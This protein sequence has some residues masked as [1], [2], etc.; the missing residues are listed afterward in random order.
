MSSCCF[1]ASST[2]E[3]GWL[4]L[5][6]GRA[7]TFQS[8]PKSRRAWTRR[9][10]SGPF[11]QISLARGSGSYVPDGAEF[12]LAPFCKRRRVMGRR[13]T[14]LYR[15]LEM[16]FPCRFSQRRTLAPTAI[17][18]SAE[19]LGVLA[20]PPPGMERPPRQAS[21]SCMSAFF[22]E[23]RTGGSD[24]ST[25]EW[26]V[27]SIWHYSARTP[28]LRILFAE[29]SGGDMLNHRPKPRM[30]RGPRKEWI[31]DERNLLQSDFKGCHGD[32][33]FDK[34]KNG[35]SENG[36]TLFFDHERRFG[37]LGRSNENK[38]RRGWL[39]EGRVG[40]GAPKFRRRRRPK[41]VF[42]HGG[43]EDGLLGQVREG[44]RVWPWFVRGHHDEKLP[45]RV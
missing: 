43:V 37:W 44:Y 2:I 33:I 9:V 12:G 24:L 36:G 35:Q 27:F 8:A 19:S 18:A 5:W 15:T 16:R 29:E 42:V 28:L 3:Q 17:Q 31:A 21:K 14:Q 4:S 10:C 1:R 34:T 23:T 13:G 26:V 30:G 22:F 25:V 7:A 32:G 40:N 39:F 41:E 45:S 38:D 6:F 11:E 20:L